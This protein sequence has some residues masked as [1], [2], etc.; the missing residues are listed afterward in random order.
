MLDFVV[1]GHVPLWIWLLYFL[2]VIF[3]YF[4]GVE[5]INRP[6]HCYQGNN[7]KARWFVAFFAIFAL[8]YCLNPDFFAYRDFAHRDYLFMFSNAED[9]DIEAY[10]Y[11]ALLCNGNFE[12]FRLIIWGGSFV[13][14][15]ITCRVLKV[16]TYLSI[17]IY[18]LL[19]N[20]IACYG[21]VT[22]AMAVFFLG[23][24]LILEKK[25]YILGIFVTLCSAFFH[26]SMVAAIAVVPIIF[27][28][29]KK[30]FQFVFYMAFFILMFFVIYSLM[31]E[32]ETIM[33]DESMGYYGRKMVSSQNKIDDGIY[34]RRGSIFGFINDLFDYLVFYIPIIGLYIKFN[35]NKIT[36]SLSKSI[37]QLYKITLAILLMAT[38]FLVIYQSFNVLFY[39]V[40]YMCMIPI[41]ILL[42]SLLSQ[43]AIKKEFVNVILGI[44]FVH[45]C[46]LYLSHMI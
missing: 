13:I 36:G 25:W 33:E 35:K 6:G 20:D 45:F 5:Y 9:K 24:S 1:E 41:S 10:Y 28:P 46:G 42:S 34:S 22:L 11:I 21:R 4:I 18:F 30:G 15:Y 27:V 38:V 12:L 40:L 17:L 37:V 8:F 2:I 43:Q 29:K 31:G 16:P 32:A 7:N 39:R 26:H 19:F 44:A 23:V 3:V 14:F